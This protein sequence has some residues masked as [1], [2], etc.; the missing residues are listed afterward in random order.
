VSAWCMCSD[1]NLGDLVRLQMYGVIILFICLYLH[2]LR[3]NSFLYLHILTSLLNMGICS[4]F[5]RTGLSEQVIMKLRISVTHFV[6]SDFKK[7]VHVLVY[8]FC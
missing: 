6:W 1:A 5:T 4:D 7:Q 8:I 2:L 3:N